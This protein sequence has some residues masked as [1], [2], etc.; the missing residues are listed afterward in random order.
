MPG[1][2]LA[3]FATMIFSSIHYIKALHPLKPF[4]L[5]AGTHDRCLRSAAP[6]LLHWSLPSFQSLHLAHWRREKRWIILPPQQWGQLQ[7][8][9]FLAVQAGSFPICQRLDRCAHRGLACT[10]TWAHRWWSAASLLDSVYTQLYM[11][12]RYG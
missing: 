5:L 2:S 3:I 10:F 11:Q 8:K 12:L 4:T 7:R 6:V 9:C 1:P